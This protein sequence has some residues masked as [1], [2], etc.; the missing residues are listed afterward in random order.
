[1]AYPNNTARCVFAFTLANGAKGYCTPH[2]RSFGGTDLGDA[3]VEAIAGL[4]ADWATNDDFQGETN[5]ALMNYPAT[6]V[7]LDTISVTS[8]D[9]TAPPQFIQ[10]VGVAGG[11]GSNALPNESAVVTTL[12]TGIVGRK[13]RGR[14]YWPI[15]TT[16]AIDAQGTLASVTLAAMQATFDALIAGLVNQGDYVLAVN[17]SAGAF[18]NQAISCVVRDTVHHQRRRNS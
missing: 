18:V 14:N 4:L 1:M 9:A 3:D 10:A 12:Y 8:L 13:Y 6:E 16:A 5:N 15:G 2:V 17:S 7:T 11:G